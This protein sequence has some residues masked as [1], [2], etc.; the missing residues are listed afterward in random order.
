MDEPHA[1]ATRVDRVSPA[2]VGTDGTAARRDAPAWADEGLAHPLTGAGP[3][4]LVMCQVY[5]LGTR[6]PCNAAIVHDTGGSS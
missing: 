4:Q 6:A 2:T 3:R 1:S 5:P